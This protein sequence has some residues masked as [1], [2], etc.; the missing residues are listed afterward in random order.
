MSNCRLND[1]CKAISVQSLLAIFCCCVSMG[2]ALASEAKL[3]QPSIFLQLGHGGIVTAVSY[4]PSGDTLASGS[5]DNTVKIW[6]ASS[7]EPLRTLSGHGDSVTAV[8]YSLSG[9][10]LASGSRDTVKIWDASSG[11]LLR[12]LSDHESAV[13]A[14]ETVKIWEASS[15][16]AL[17]RTLSGHDDRVCLLYTSP[18]PRD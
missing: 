6:D 3:G 10:T 16:G 9:D 15:G 1:K 4:S 8:S 12:T 13:N 7:G 5:W 17:L 11:E 2:V 18:S 14:D